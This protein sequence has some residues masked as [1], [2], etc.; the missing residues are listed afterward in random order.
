MFFKKRIYLYKAVEFHIAF[1]DK[2]SHTKIYNYND[3]FDIIGRFLESLCE[4]LNKKL[5]Y[6]EEESMQQRSENQLKY[7]STQSQIGFKFFKEEIF[8]KKAEFMNQ[9]IKPIV[10]SIERYIRTFEI[11]LDFNFNEK[12]KI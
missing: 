7:I 5:L 1:K 9:L 12:I 2:Y 11:E 8:S 4:I 10:Y 6:Q 3:I